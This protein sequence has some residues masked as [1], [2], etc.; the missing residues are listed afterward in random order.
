[1]QFIYQLWSGFLI[2]FFIANFL[3]GIHIDGLEN[4]L[5]SGF[6][7]SFG[8][9]LLPRII[10]FF[11]LNVNYVSFYLVGL[12]YNV[13]YYYFLSLLFVG[14]LLIEPNS[15]ESSLFLINSFRGIPLGYTEVILINA[16]IGMMLVTLNQWLMER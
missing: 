10:E 3:P 4:Y 1:M 8:I 2:F 11:N 16:I 9:A 7:Y 13:L 5:V 6:L 14:V 12:L 15:A